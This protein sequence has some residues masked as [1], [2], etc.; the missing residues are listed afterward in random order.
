MFT[1]KRLCK[2][3]QKK[4]VV[5]AARKWGLL[6]CTSASS[7]VRHGYGVRTERPLRNRSSIV[8][9]RNKNVI[10]FIGRQ[11]GDP[12]H[13]RSEDSRAFETRK[14]PFAF[15]AG[16]GEEIVKIPMIFVGPEWV[17]TFTTG[18]RVASDYR[19]S[20]GGVSTRISSDAVREGC[21]AGSVAN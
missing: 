13:L 18:S 20:T 4:S 17:N 7:P 1:R 12:Q 9:S 10:L 3:A 11:K 2:S 16:Y 5:Y 19:V 8:T 14:N 21:D 6:E 15:N